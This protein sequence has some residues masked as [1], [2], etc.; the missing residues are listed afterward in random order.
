MDSIQK[1]FCI[2]IRKYEM[3]Y[4]TDK[5]KNKKHRKLKNK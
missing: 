3:K 5:N 4:D 1:F 2:N